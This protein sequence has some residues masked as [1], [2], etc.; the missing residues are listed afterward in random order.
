[1]A[2]VTPVHKTEAHWMEN[3]VEGPD[4]DL[5]RLPIC[6]CWPQDA[7]PLITWGMV[8]TRG[9]NRPRVNLAIYR[10]QLIGRNKL[11][12]RWLAHRGGA[13]DFRAFQQ[14]HPGKPYPVSVVI[15]AD[16]A[17]LLAAVT[18]VPDTLSEYAFA[19]LL[20]GRRSAMAAHWL[21][22][23]SLFFYAWWDPRYL[24]L[25]LLVFVGLGAMGQ[26]LVL[27]AARFWWEVYSKTGTKIRVTA[28]DLEAEG[29]LREALD[30]FESIG[31]VTY[32]D[33]V[34]ERIRAL[35]GGIR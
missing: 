14:K 29:K 20:R 25:L 10:L 11:I 22:A 28:I 17:T 6:T 18:P 24:P 35:G 30:L 3:V 32:Q 13:Q 7:G 19:G 9:P 5:D 31:D 4:V 27:H 33:L 15:G 21:L 26:S 1:M 16:P 8:L 23:G 12:M 2:H 34:D